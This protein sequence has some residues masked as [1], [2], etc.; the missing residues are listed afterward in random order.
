MPVNR[1]FL[2]LTRNSLCRPVMPDFDRR[3]SKRTAIENHNLVA[4]RQGF[5]KGR[6]IRRVDWPALRAM[7][8]ERGSG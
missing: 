5:R 4:M 3:D 8:S 6:L 7:S 2:R 1:A